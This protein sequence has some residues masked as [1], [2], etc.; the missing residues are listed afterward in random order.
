VESCCDALLVTLTLKGRVSRS[1]S[2]ASCFVLYGTEY[3]SE[4]HRTNLKM[5]S[6][7]LLCGTTV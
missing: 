5:S 4:F 7:T 6:C 3:G 2:C 1:G